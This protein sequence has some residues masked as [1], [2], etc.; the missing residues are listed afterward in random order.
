MPLQYSQEYW[1]N[2]YDGP[3]EKTFNSGFYLDLILKKCYRP[4]FGKNPVSFADIGCG[5]GQTLNE[6]QRLLGPSAKVYG[7]ECQEIP[8]ERQTSPN[9]I[10][11][12][13]LEIYK[14]L[15]PVDLL[16]VACS[17][18][19]PW[20]QQAEF[21]NAARQLT[22]KAAIFA[23]VYLTDKYNIPQD[24]LRKVIYKSRDSFGAAVKPY[25]F[26]LHNRFYDFYTINL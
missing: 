20:D 22:K 21:V 15:E 10:F 3:Y 1:D 11:G 18:Y 13:F 19:I 9:I 14:K 4:V 17:M 26:N 2:Y 6:A 24:P 5:P 23:N 7:V 25:G 8:P 16:Y 12:N